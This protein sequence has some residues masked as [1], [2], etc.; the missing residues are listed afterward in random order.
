MIYAKGAPTALCYLVQLSRPG[1][2]KSGLGL[3]PRV[4]SARKGAGCVC[5][6]QWGQ[7]L[8]LV[9]L[10]LSNLRKLVGDLLKPY[11]E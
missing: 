4:Q 1:T 3:H 2:S 10:S 5:L 6:C 11:H 7:G 9:F 8:K